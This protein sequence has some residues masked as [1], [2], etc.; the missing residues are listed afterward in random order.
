MPGVPRRPRGAISALALLAFP[1]AA[2]TQD[3]DDRRLTLGEVPHVTGAFT[4]DGVLDEPF[5]SETLRIELHLETNPAENLPAPVSTFVYLS[6]NGTHLLVAFDARDPQPELIRAYLRDRDTAWQ[7][8]IVGIAIDTFNDQIRGFEFFANAL[9]VQIDATIDDSGGGEDDSWDAI[10]ESMGS[11]TE[12]G[13]VVEMAVPFSQIR[14]ENNDD[15]KTWGID[16][17]R[18]YPRDDRHRLAVNPQDRGRNCF[19]C[20]F[21]TVRGF[22]RAEAGTDI[23]VVPSLTAS[24]TDTRD[25]ALNALVDGDS[26]SDVGVNVSWGITPDLTA[27]LAINPDFS[28]VEADVAQLEVNNNFALFFPETRPFFLE[29]ASFFSTPMRA[30]FTRTIAD[31]DIGA[32]LTGR[33]GDNTYGFFAARDTVTNLLFPG[34]LGSSSTSLQKDSDTL[35]GRYQYNF[36]QSS[37][38]GALFTDRSGDSYHNRVAGFDGRYR[39]SDQHSLNFQYLDSETEYPDEIVA[40]FEQPTGSFSGDATQISYNYNTRNWNVSTNYLRWGR[41]FR[42]DAGFMSQVDVETRNASF[43]RVWHGE[44]DNWWNRIQA[45]A[46]TGSDYDTS[47]QI[48]NRW[49]E[50]F[51][52]FNGPLQSFLQ[53]GFGS[54]KQFWDGVYDRDFMFMYGRIQPV[55]AIDIQGSIQRS[56][57]VD[58]ANSRLGDQQNHQLQLNWNVN[59]HLLIRLRHTNSVLDT[60]EGPNIFKAQLDDWRITWQFNI[61]SFVRLTMQRQEVNR[62]LA[63]WSDPLVDAHSVDMGAQFLYSYKLNPQT[64][65]FFGYSDN[66]VENDELAS[67]TRTDRTFFLKFSYAW[68]P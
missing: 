22:A 57:Q 18:M 66:H 26:S 56:E 31:P 33:D 4:I 41:G 62:N 2:F 34:P 54:S 35:V 24:R 3:G 51:F 8:D 21:S 50:A 40:D 25:P 20:Q 23:E 61:R 47:G 28:Q 59:R 17:V 38:V 16:L 44:E 48:L 10:W 5:W 45:G 27:N 15:I 68:L 42:A 13:Y 6:E 29:G 43:N 46:N 7:D 58:F 9:G 11:I 19:V 65:A 1:A 39:M 30:V 63:V 67:L 55:G 37:T 12:T 49:R 52:G 32:K 14:F 53:G 36:G 60:K 64:V